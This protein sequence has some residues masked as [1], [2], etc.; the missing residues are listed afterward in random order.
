M[1]PAFELDY[2][3]RGCMIAIDVQAESF[4]VRVYF[5]GFAANGVAGLIESYLCKT[6]E[7]AGFVVECL[8]AGQ[9]VPR[10]YRSTTVR[11]RVRCQRSD[12]EA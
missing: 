10:G 8:S 3:V 4:H 11:E 1:E 12:S 6:P 2:E 9:S 5:P 7:E